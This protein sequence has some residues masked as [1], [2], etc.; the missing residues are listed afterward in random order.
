GGGP[1]RG[2]VHL[3]RLAVDHA[4]GG[5]APVLEDLGGGEGGGV[6]A[7]IKEDPGQPAPRLLREVDHL[8]DVGQVVHPEPDRVR[9][10]LV[11]QPEVVR[12]REDLHIQNAYVMTGAPG[13]C[14]GQLDA[15]R[16]E[17]G[18]DLRGREPA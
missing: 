2:G 12:V 5:A 7:Y 14:G 18:G 4:V 9:A 17:A 1:E 13:G 8:G 6:P 16:L 3:P 10:P 11:E 15:E